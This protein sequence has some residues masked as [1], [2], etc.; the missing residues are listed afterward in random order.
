MP[1][2]QKIEAASIGDWHT[3]EDCSGLSSVHSDLRVINERMD[4]MDETISA[5]YRLAATDREVI[6]QIMHANYAKAQEDRNEIIKEIREQ[7]AEMKGPM[8]IIRGG[9][10]VVIVVRVIGKWARRVILWSAPVATAVYS[11]LAAYQAYIE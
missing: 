1:T 5:N 9:E 8:D 6:K 10:Q 7:N 3:P 11:A 4:K 2:L